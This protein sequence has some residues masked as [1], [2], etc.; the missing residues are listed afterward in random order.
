MSVCYDC[1]RGTTPCWRHA[2]RDLSTGSPS[3][4]EPKSIIRLNA[5]SNPGYRPYCGP[6]PGLVRMD[7]IAPFFWR[8]TRCGAEHDERM[9]DDQPDPAA[10][11]PTG[12][13]T[14]G[15]ADIYT[16]ADAALEAYPSPAS[17]AGAPPTGGDHRAELARLERLERS[18]AEDLAAADRRID[19][20]ERDVT[21]LLEQR[22]RLAVANAEVAEL[23]VTLQMELAEARAALGEGWLACGLTLPQAIRLKTRAL[24]N[25]AGPVG[26]DHHEPGCPQ[27]DLTETECGDCGRTVPLAPM[28]KAGV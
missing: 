4:M 27:A 9:P 1:G 8:C 24:E 20:L 25:L 16:S 28:K 3:P 13:E 18:S 21:S 10:A 6:C 26:S 2:T 14:D 11:A 5:E 22:S 17:F 12:C 15:L 19:E 7:K 23:N